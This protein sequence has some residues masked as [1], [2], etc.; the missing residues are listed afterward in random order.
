MNTRTLSACSV[1]SEL[2]LLSETHIG[3]FLW[4]DP[5]NIA[6]LHFVEKNHATIL[7]LNFFLLGFISPQQKIWHLSRSSVL[8]LKC[9]GVSFALTVEGGLHFQARSCIPWEFWYVR[10]GKAGANYQHTF[11][12]VCI[13]SRWQQY[14]PLAADAAHLEG[15]LL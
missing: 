11:S 6:N 14:T 8:P 15:W 10:A 12:L 3:H 1:D 13:W 4:V 2:F 5:F 7:K 9:S